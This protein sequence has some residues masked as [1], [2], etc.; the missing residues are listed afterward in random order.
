LTHLLGSVGNV[1]VLRALIAYAAPLS[2][3]QIASDSGLT[4]RGARMVLDGL[5]AQGIVRVLGSSGVQLFVIAADHPL[6]PALGKLFEAERE[7]WEA[8]HQGLVKGLAALPKVRSAW[9]YGS[10]ARGE[11]APRSDIDLAVVMNSDDLDCAALVRDD[12]QNLS[13]ALHVPVSAVVL[14]PSDIAGMP[15]HD[16][17]WG[18][19]VRDARIVKGVGPEQ[20]AARCAAVPA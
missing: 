17:W 9:L 19:V 16:R 14:R 5:I 6:A 12:I 7:I 2:A 13:D 8:F 10:V 3:T 18:E 1:R 15:A 11:D 4:S 20:E